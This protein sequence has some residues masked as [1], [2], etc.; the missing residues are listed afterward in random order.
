M[1]WVKV[2]DRLPPDMEPVMVTVQYISGSRDVYPEARWN[3]KKGYW[4]MVAP[5]AEDW[6]KTNMTITHWIQWLEPPED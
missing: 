5:S 4:E 3:Q 2:T 1:N 6:W